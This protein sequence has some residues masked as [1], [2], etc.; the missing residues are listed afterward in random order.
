MTNEQKALAIRLRSEGTTYRKIAVKLGVSD[1][2]A[3]KFLIS[4]KPKPKPVPIQK[5][6]SK[7]PTLLPPH[8]LNTRCIIRREIDPAK[9]GARPLTRSEMYETLATAWRNTAQL[10]PR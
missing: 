1:S 8:Q 10:A 4:L 2:A 6:E 7:V 5:S 9:R 3:Y